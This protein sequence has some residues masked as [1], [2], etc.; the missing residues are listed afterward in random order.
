MQILVVGETEREAEIPKAVAGVRPLNALQVSAGDLE[1]V[2]RLVSGGGHESPQSRL[3]NLLSRSRAVRERQVLPI[4]VRVMIDPL[5]EG[6]EHRLR[7]D[8]R[9]EFSTYLLTHTLVLNR[10]QRSDFLPLSTHLGPHPSFL[11]CLPPPL[12]LTGGDANNP[13]PPDPPHLGEELTK[14][15]VQGQVLL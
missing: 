10:V 13:P 14:F 4:A 6:V 11:T 9:A 5:A 8:V 1:L 2:E 12:K 7:H 15:K 3:V